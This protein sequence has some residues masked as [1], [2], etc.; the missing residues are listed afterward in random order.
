MFL[1]CLE[2]PIVVEL[3]TLFS[4]DWV[5]PLTLEFEFFVVGAISFDNE[6]FDLVTLPP[7]VRPAYE[8]AP[9]VFST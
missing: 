2:C 9:P 1:E 7:L 3:F 4:V 5:C 6:L 8:P